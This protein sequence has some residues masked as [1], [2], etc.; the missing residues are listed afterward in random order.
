M[1]RGKRPAPAA[2]APRPEARK[3]RKK[4]PAV[5]KEDRPSIRPG[6][7]SVPSAFGAA[8]R[9]TSGCALTEGQWRIKFSALFSAAGLY[10]PRG[11]TI[12][13]RGV[14][15]QGVRKTVC[16]WAGRCFGLVLDLCNN[17]RWKSIEDVMKYYNVGAIRSGELTA[18]G[19]VDPIWGI[20]P[21]KRVTVA[22]LDGT[23]QM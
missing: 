11:G 13:Q 4:N 12:T 2:A 17:G 19:G 20:W 10:N 6:F 5:P 7:G 1:A 21:W 14:T 16:Q 18:Q 22:A 8:L 15:P 23:K 9:E 3:S